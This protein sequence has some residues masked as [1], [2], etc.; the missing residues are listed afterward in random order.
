MLLSLDTKVLT[1][2]FLSRLTIEELARINTDL[3][4]DKA[5]MV[6]LED[7]TVIDGV[8]C[9]GLTRDELIARIVKKIKLLTHFNKG[10][11]PILKL[12]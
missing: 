10:I 6:S 5:G 8:V 4:K 2:K 11:K 3:S 7:F 9:R 1:P 12:S